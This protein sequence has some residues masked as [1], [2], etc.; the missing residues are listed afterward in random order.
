MLVVSILTASTLSARPFDS[1]ADLTTGRLEIEGQLQPTVIQNRCVL[2]QRALAPALVMGRE[3][4]P[5][6]VRIEGRATIPIADHHAY[7]APAERIC[8]AFF[9]GPDADHDG[10]PEDSAGSDPANGH[11]LRADEQLVVDWDA[12]V[13]IDTRGQAVDANFIQL[14]NTLRVGWPDHG[15]L[16]NW[17]DAPVMTGRLHVE[18][19]GDSDQGWPPG[20]I[21]APQSYAPDGSRTRYAVWSEEGLLR[22]DLS[23][24][25][26]SFRGTRSDQDDVAI[27]HGVYGWGNLEGP[28]SATGFAVGMYGVG[29]WAGTTQGGRLENNQYNLVLGH[30]YRSG[31]MEPAPACRRAPPNCAGKVNAGGSH[32]FSDMLIEGATRSN[33][34]V[35]GGRRWLFTNAWIESRRSGAGGHSV[36]LGAGTSARRRLPCG[37][38][39]DWNEPCVRPAGARIGGSVRFVGGTIDG[40]EG[41]PKWEA[42]LL[43]PGYGPRWSTWVAA[44]LRESVIGGFGPSRHRAFHFHPDARGMIDLREVDL[45]GDDSLPSYPG[46]TH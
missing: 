45:E 21:P 39:S 24:L 25:S 10:Y 34:V 17:V 38:D 3:R 35:F 23:R 22:A 5:W 41:H 31:M 6:R 32:H 44:T 13:V 18:I 29:N 16:G 4:L 42:L 7:R 33:L 37:L 27:L 14:G 8:V 9:G 20:K 43:G 36:I 40:D 30:P 2:M 15:V 12:D 11:R 1:V 19:R 26:R 46:L 28:T